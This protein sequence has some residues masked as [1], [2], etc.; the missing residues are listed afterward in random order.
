MFPRVGIFVMVPFRNDVTE[1]ELN[2]MGDS[3]HR[4]RSKDPGF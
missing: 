1:T 2:T 4:V 3:H